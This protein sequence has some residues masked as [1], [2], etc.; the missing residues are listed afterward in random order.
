MSYAIC[1]TL[2]DFIVTYAY[3]KKIC[4]VQVF[5]YRGVVRHLVPQSP[6]KHQFF[7]LKDF[8]AASYTCGTFAK[9]RSESPAQVPQIRLKVPHHRDGHMEIC[10]QMDVSP[11]SYPTIPP[12]GAKN[13]GEPEE[14]GE[15]QAMKAAVPQVSLKRAGVCPGGPNR[16][17]SNKPTLLPEEVQPC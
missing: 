16:W 3:R 8:L 5:F 14:L 2:R 17:R 15:S 13:Q 12:A 10:V 9:F 11:P 1:G 6:A 4:T 7:S